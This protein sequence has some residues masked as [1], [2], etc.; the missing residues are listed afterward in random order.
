MT[1]SNT[2]RLK[3]SVKPKDILI[4]NQIMILLVEDAV[5]DSLGT[6]SLLPV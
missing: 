2:F 4:K 1:A 3:Y 6:K 5:T